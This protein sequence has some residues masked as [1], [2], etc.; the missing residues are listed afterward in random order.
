MP[1][2]PKGKAQAEFIRNR[3][4]VGPVVPL[5]RIGGTQIT[6]SPLTAANRAEVAKL[7]AQ[8]RALLP[9]LRNR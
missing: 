3:K 2:D 4:V 6:R 5:P 7:R 1:K 9:G 8:V